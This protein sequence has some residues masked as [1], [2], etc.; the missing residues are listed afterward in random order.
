MKN[1]R[2]VIIGSIFSLFFIGILFYFVDF[3]NVIKVLAQFRTKYIVILLVVYMTSMFFRSF[4]WYLIINHKYEVKFKDIFNALALCYMVNNLLP[5]KIGEFVRIIYISKI[6]KNSKSFL[7]GTVVV[8]RFLDVIVVCLFLFFSV[9]FSNTIQGI[10]GQNKIKLIFI[11]LVLS[12]VCYLVF[13]TE[14]MRRIFNIFPE[15][16]SKRLH[17]MFQSFE[18]SFIIINSPFTMIKVCSLSLVIWFLT[19]VMS[20]TVLH[21]LNITIPFYAYFFVVSAGV[22]G[23]VIPST[24]GGIG[25]YHAVS[26]SSLLLFGVHKDIAI[27][28]AIIS[29]AFDF[30]P[31]V[32]LGV[33]ILIKN[34]YSLITLTKEA[35]SI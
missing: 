10:I 27:T 12:T 34:H 31:N 3:K 4:R 35:E 17:S 28:Y 8:E 18:S 7:L 6:Y 16:L 26:M 23:M 32:I 25:V 24:S 1:K 19:C 15:R 5:A 29:H 33:V 2:V 13:K 20:Y 22:L 9:F 14:A 21:G 11:F 30:I